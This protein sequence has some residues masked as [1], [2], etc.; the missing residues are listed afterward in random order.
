MRAGRLSLRSLLRS[1]PFACGLP[2]RVDASTPEAFLSSPSR[3]PE[4]S[5]DA[6][7]R[8]P[9]RARLLSRTKSCKGLQV[10]RRLSIRP[11][12]PNRERTG[13]PLRLLSPKPS[14]PSPL[15]SIGAS[16][17]VR[18]SVFAFHLSVAR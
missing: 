18:V 7:V 3:P 6:A 5:T 11:F 10:L 1:V 12:S 17:C 14:E 8:P 15:L 13:K 16:V 9:S 4:V 2:G